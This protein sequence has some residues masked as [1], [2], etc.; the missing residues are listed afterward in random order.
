MKYDLHKY[1]LSSLIALLLFCVNFSFAQKEFFTVTGTVEDKT[2]EPIPSVNIQLKGNIVNAVTD[3]NGA[4]T[5]NLSNKEATLIFSSI[6]YR[7]QEVEV[8]GKRIMNVVME[9]D[10]TQLQDAVVVGYGLQ[11]KSVVTGAI[12]SVKNKDFK[13]NPLLI[14]VARYKVK[15]RA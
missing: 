14:L 9:D 8:D 13:I 12:A 2:G 11:K 10:M 3:K 1:R 7:T 15:C 6:G 5:I 4:F